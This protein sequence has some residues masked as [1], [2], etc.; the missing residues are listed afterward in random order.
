MAKKYGSPCVEKVNTPVQ[1]KKTLDRHS[2]A[3]PV[4]KVSLLLADTEQSTDD[5][6]QDNCFRDLGNDFKENEAYLDALS[7]GYAPDQI[8][9]ISIY[10]DGVAYTNNE[11]FL[12]FYFTNLLTGVQRLIWVLRHYGYFRRTRGKH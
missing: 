8:K 11:S 10:F 9:P 6:S 5:D 2:I 3:H 7:E 12:A 1:Y 4:R